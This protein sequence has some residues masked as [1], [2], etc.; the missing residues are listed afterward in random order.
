MLDQEFPKMHR[1]FRAPL[2]LVGAVVTDQRGTTL[3][4][5]SNPKA[6]RPA[7][8]RF[9]ARSRPSGRAPSR[10]AGAHMAVLFTVPN[11]CSVTLGRLGSSKRSDVRFAIEKS[12]FSGDDERIT[13]VGHTGIGLDASFV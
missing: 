12:L 7:C 2:I 9:P 13:Q 1:L 5:N 6:G 8:P 11:L 3:H 10:T 4:A